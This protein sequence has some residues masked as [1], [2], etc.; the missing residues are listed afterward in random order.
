MNRPPT[1]AV[2]GTVYKRENED[3]AATRVRVVIEDAEGNSRTLESNEVGNFYV[4]ESVW[5]P[6]FPL[7]V[8]LEANGKSVA[9]RSEI[10]REGACNACHKGDGDARHMPR[11]FVEVAK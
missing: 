8:K 4:E 7:H 10:A 1:F 3:E 9:M 5:K 2:A 6:T 11:V